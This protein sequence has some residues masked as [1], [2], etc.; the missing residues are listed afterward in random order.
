MKKPYNTPEM[1]ESVLNNAMLTHAIL[2]SIA[3]DDSDD[4]WNAIKP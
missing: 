2:N 4:E 1:E 3:D